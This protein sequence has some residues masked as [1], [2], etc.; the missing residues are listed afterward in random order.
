MYIH[1]PLPHATT[2]RHENLIHELFQYALHLH[3]SENLGLQKSLLLLY[4]S[5]RDAKT[6]IA[7]VSCFFYH[8][9]GFAVWRAW[10]LMRSALLLG[11]WQIPL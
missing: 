8:T 2:Y 1:A 5:L 6:T 7:T 3:I 9:S 11:I 10:L 4:E